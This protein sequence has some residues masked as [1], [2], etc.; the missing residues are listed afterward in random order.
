MCENENK[1]H[2]IREDIDGNRQLCE[3]SGGKN[4][5]TAEYRIFN[6]FS[7]H[8]LA[9]LNGDYLTFYTI[10]VAW[11]YIKAKGLC[12]NMFKIVR[13]WRTDNEGKA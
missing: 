1:C 12:P 7:G 3:I 9:T 11:E 4:A 10:V 13:V 2:F 5:M 6:G 8:Y